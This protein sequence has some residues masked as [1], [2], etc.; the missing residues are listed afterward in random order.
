MKKLLLKILVRVVILIILVL[1]L[2]LAV[3]TMAE[4]R[5]E[6]V[7]DLSVESNQSLPV[8]L[9]EVLT[10]MSFNI[11][12][13]GLGAQEDFV[14][15]GGS[16]GRADSIEDV[17]YYLEGILSLVD[18]YPADIYLMQEMDLNARRSYYMNQVDALHE[19]LGP[20]YSSSFAYNFNALFVPFP[21]S[22]SDHIGYVESGIQT[23]SRFR[24]DES[25][26]Y[27]LPGS[28]SWPL[29][30]ANLKRA[31]MVSRLPVE[32]S[33]NELVVINVHLSAYDDGSMR[34][35]EMAMLREMMIAE[36]EQGNY[37]VVGGD[38][39][40]TFPEAVNTFP[41]LSDE[42]Y[43]AHPIESDFLPAGFSF[44]IDPT[45]PTARLLNQPYEPSDPMTQYYIID[46]YVVSDNI[47]VEEIYTVDAQFEYSDHNPVMLSIILK[48][49]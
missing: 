36:Y 2:S 8:P 21:V 28:F 15:D 43:V 20:Q 3:L 31:M 47:M 34:L 30:V 48:G 32:G 17:Q 29:R 11:G 42:Y 49:E 41:V 26:R 22:L 46:G 40:Q 35:Q 1:A 24:V 5:P 13:A 18:E 19:H 33:E 25:T 45:T 4:Y 7:E 38:F 14:M 27:Q 39:N 37:V 9:D 16:K 6:A 23:L 44:Q 10:F 12:Y